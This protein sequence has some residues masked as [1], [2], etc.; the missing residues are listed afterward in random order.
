MQAGSVERWA[1]A[2]NGEAPKGVRLAEEAICAALDAESAGWR[3]YFTRSDL[4]EWIRF[5]RACGG[6][7]I[8]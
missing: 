5:L 3:Y 6:F 1:K 7:R 4:R 2:H 8:D